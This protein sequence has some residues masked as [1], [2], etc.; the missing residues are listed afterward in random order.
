[1][2]ARIGSLAALLGASLLACAS[3]PPVTPAPAPAPPP[4]TDATPPTPPAPAN[5]P[6][7]LIREVV[8]DN[9][10]ELTFLSLDPAL[11][12]DVHKKL[13]ERFF[14]VYPAEVA[15]FN[16]A[17][18]TSVTFIVDPSY[19]GV[20]ETDNGI[21][22]FNANWYHTHPADIDIVT[23]EVM[24]IVQDYPNDAGPGWIT[25]GI[26]DFARARFGVSNAEGGWVLPALKAEHR[27]TTSY[28]V[29]AR[30]FLWLDARV[31]PGLIKT[32]DAA[33]R[34]HRYEPALWTAETGK[35]I[36]QLWA[37][38]VVDPKLSS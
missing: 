26:A 2:K 33:M 32:L 24:H 21:V 13:I 4:A 20:A 36:D 11:D 10:Y 27:Y 35:T 25:E 14:A 8:R 34:A 6:G 9:G 28:Q 30:F 31:K 12:P 7:V 3:A 19:P 17:A 22:L 29:T 1:M 5:G 23:H 16:P 15:A 38:Y 37:A 18:R